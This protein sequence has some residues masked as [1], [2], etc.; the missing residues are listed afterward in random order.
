MTM[1]RASAA[2]AVPLAA[3]ILL[4]CVPRQE[5]DAVVA[6]NQHL[7]AQLAQSQAQ[8]ATISGRAEV[9]RGGVTICSRRTVLS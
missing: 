4:G 2:V 9:C 5:Y 7:K 8:L 6:E 1:K 3:M